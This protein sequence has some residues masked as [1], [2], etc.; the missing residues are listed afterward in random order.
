MFFIFL[1]TIAKKLDS[2]AILSPAI[3][4]VACSGG[5]DS[6]ALTLLM[7]EWAKSRGN[8]LIA[9][10]VDHDL[11]KASAEE[12]KQVGIWLSEKAIPHIIVKWEGE[13]PVSNIQEQ[14]RNARYRL[15]TEYCRSH[16]IEYLFV[17]HHLEDQAETFLLRLMRGSGVD[18]LGAMQER[19]VYQDI[20]ILRPLLDT[21]KQI[22]I[23]CLDSLNQPFI[24]DPSNENGDY[25]RVKIRKLLPVL[26]ENGF[27]LP[28]LA[29][30]ARTMQRSSGYLKQVTQ[31]WLKQH[32]VFHAEGYATLAT[33]PDSEEIAYRVLNQILKI[34]GC[35][36]KPAR[37]EALET[38]YRRLQDFAF[39]SATL[40]GC[41]FVKKKERW[42][43]MREFRAVEGLITLSGE[44]E[45]KWDRFTLTLKKP[46]PHYT[47][48]ALTQKDWLLLAKTNN[49]KN[50]LPDKQ[51]LYTLPCLRNQD[52]TIIA[53]PHLGIGFAVIPKCYPARTRLSL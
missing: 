37:L 29:K 14:A 26:Q 50:S 30:T 10:T 40:G 47:V 33:L 16:G 52:N 38:L 17:A 20:T 3:V 53:V 5:S 27:L 6:L 25:D 8:Q 42:I 1:N 2:F 12:A 11:R 46:Y 44:T 19:T 4:A 28:R 39:T 9:L 7:D 15:L 51:I 36:A 49:L 35:N 41:L 43:V 18:G 21:P 22:L 45:V 34:I 23:D 24:R 13:K 32:A 48:G 31:E